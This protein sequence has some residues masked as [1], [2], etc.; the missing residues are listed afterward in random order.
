[1]VGDLIS[2]F[3]SSFRDDRL[4]ENA[5]SSVEERDKRN[6]SELSSISQEAQAVK[7]QRVIDSA[8]P[9]STRSNGT[10]VIASLESTIASFQY[11]IT[12]RLDSLDR[13]AEERFEQL[14]FKFNEVD[15]RITA[16]EEAG[17][18]RQIV[19]DSLLDRVRSLESNQESTSERIAVQE[20]REIPQPTVSVWTPTAPIS[21]KIWLLGDSNSANKL[22]FGEGKGKLGAALPGSGDFFPKIE[23]LPLPDS[24]T[25][26][27][28][29]DVIIAVGTND[30]RV[31]TSDPEVLARTMY[32]YVHTLTSKHLSTHVHLSGVLPTSHS[33]IGTNTR[34]DTYN[35]FLA[36]MAVTL[37]RVS[38]ID[39][40]VFKTRE[41]NL[42]P[43]LA[44]GT[45]DPLHL[46]GEGYRLFFSRLK[47]AL[48]VRLG[49][50]NFQRGRTGLASGQAA[51]GEEG[52]RGQGTGRGGGQ[53]GRGSGRGGL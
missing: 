10:D 50:P 18:S 33:G 12:K 6:F 40:K 9:C 45:S 3:N 49:L 23:S 48:R 26:A 41:G 32:N 39:V 53:R 29:S 16:V 11:N 42:R 1:M 8:S 13:R 22:K 20:T 2:K 31:D 15:L 4:D 52:T 47:Y 30:L 43:R 7:V 38:Y 51:Q 35:H 27:N 21:T 44:E 17:S 37:P 25:F 34:I 46:N 5:P 14:M 19:I 24:D 36:D 28:V